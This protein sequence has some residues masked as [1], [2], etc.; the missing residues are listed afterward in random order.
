MTSIG[1]SY[2]ARVEETIS[3]EHLTK[4]QVAEEL[5]DE[6]ETHDAIAS[7]VPVE[8]IESRVRNFATG[9][10]EQTATAYKQ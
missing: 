7:A 5:E 10:G 1:S 6:R 2:F 4:D 9:V 8:G 3:S